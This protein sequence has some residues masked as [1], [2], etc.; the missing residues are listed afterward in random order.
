MDGVSEGRSPSTQGGA[1]GRGQGCLC[2]PEG[3][4]VAGFPRTLAS[5]LSGPAQSFIPKAPSSGWGTEHHPETSL[6][7]SGHV[8]GSQG[9]GH[10]DGDGRTEGGLQVGGGEKAMFLQGE[11]EEGSEL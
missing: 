1:A 5:I 7:W 11:R 9:Y 4:P 2:S 8:S 3:P 10:P 6:N